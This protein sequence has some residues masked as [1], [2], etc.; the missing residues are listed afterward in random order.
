M[1][2]ENFEPLTGTCGLQV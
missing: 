2:S 1:I